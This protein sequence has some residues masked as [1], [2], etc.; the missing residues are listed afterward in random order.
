MY[1][2]TSREGLIEML[3]AYCR[4]G[5]MLTSDDVGMKEGRKVV[6]CGLRERKQSKRLEN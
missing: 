6:E 4:I 5:T 1:E 3:E 2:N